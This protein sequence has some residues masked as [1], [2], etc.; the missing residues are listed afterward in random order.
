MLVISVTL[1][2]R[3][4]AD[5]DHSFTEVNSIKK[6]ALKN[7][8]KLNLKRSWEMVVR[9]RISKPLPPLTKGIERKCW[10]K[11]WH[12]FWGESIGLGPSCWQLVMQLV[13]QLVSSRLYILRVCKY[14][15]YP[16]DQ[17]TKLFDLLIMHRLLYGIEIWGAASQGKYLDR[18]DNFVNVPL[19]SD[20]QTTYMW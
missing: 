7:R 18:I 14:F 17:L 5:Q 9:G 13:I 15:G 1:S 4:S 16:K 10:L 19:S 6:F 20:I 8:M 3:V 12:N 11:L 2:M